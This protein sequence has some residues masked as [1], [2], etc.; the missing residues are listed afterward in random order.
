VL[1][2]FYRYTPP[3]K[4]ELM[5]ILVELS[6]RLWVSHQAA[7]EYQENRIGM[8]KKQ[9]D[10]YDQIKSIFK[11][12][13]NKIDEK[14]N[15]FKNHSFIDINIIRE[16]LKATIE[17]I[18]QVL[19]QQRQ[20]HPDLV[21]E[22]I[23]EGDVI[24]ESLDSLLEGKVGPQYSLQELTNIYREGKERYESEIPPGYADIKDKKGV[25]IY[26]DL[27]MWYQMIDKAKEENR[28]MLL[29]H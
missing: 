8:I 22:D 19:D 15:S 24:R 20:E 6:E 7:L 1:L 18:K 9:K 27:I 12:P 21:G 25:K 2:G 11:E 28:P 16:K 5:K 14:L 26:G 3:T 23:L 10:A 4:E 29:N 13:Y 17:D